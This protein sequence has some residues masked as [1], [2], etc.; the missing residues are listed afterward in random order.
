[1]KYV[2]GVTPVMNLDDTKRMLAAVNVLVSR[3]S[4]LQS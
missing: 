4:E 3:R 1:M 2:E